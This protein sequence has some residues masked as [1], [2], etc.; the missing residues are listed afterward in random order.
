MGVTVEIEVGEI[1]DGFGGAV[2]R[3]LT[4]SYER[5]RVPRG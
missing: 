4:G 5:T 2:S 3:H 1:G